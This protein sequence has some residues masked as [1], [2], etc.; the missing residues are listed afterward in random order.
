MWLADALGRGD[1]KRAQERAEAGTA[2]GLYWS[3]EVEGLG[4]WAGVVSGFRLPQTVPHS[5]QSKFRGRVSKVTYVLTAL[6]SF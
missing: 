1:F 4:V 5:L 3:P 6:D 2:C